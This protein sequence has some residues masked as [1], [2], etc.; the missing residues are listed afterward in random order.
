MHG[1]PPCSLRTRLEAR[2]R[3]ASAPCPTA[4]AADSRSG[5]AQAGPRARMTTWCVPPVA[6]LMAGWRHCN[7]GQLAEHCLHACLP[8]TAWAD[9]LPTC[10]RCLRTRRVE[11][12]WCRAAASCRPAGTAAS[13]RW[14][15]RE[16]S[17]AGG[18]QGAGAGWR[19]ARASLAALCRQL[20]RF[21]GRQPPAALPSSFPTLCRQAGAG[22]EADP[23]CGAAAPLPGGADRPAGRPRSAARR[24]QA[25]GGHWGAPGWRLCSLPA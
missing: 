4:P 8:A 11:C 2:R 5:A 22:P 20:L 13:S 7:A 3:P 15:T 23:E 25:H 24:A 17:G 12:S 19:G 9:A 1:R 14:R 16:S 18:L 10:R 6:E 21:R